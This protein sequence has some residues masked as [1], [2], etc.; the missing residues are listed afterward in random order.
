MCEYIIIT[1]EA[2]FRTLLDEDIQLFLFGESD[3]GNGYMEKTDENGQP[4]I[5]TWYS[6]VDGVRYNYV[7]EYSKL[8]KYTIFEY[9]AD[10]N[11]VK[12][13]EKDFC[14]DEYDYHDDS[15]DSDDY[16]YDNYDNHDDQ[17]NQNDQ[18]D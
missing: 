14:V 1:Y 4:E 8:K 7:V 17:D 9:D 10:L 11:I 2:I 18:N 12:V 6:V 16:D 5:K 15:D 3:D 13:I